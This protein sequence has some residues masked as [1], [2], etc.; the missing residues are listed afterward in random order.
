VSAAGDYRLDKEK[1]NVNKSARPSFTKQ[2][3]DTK[4]WE[5]GTRF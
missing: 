2:S 3:N 4:L 1:K 5:L